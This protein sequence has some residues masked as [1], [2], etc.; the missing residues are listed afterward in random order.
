MSWYDC[1]AECM[2]VIV[3]EWW[4]CKRNPAQLPTLQLSVCTSSRQRKPS[5]Q[6]DHLTICE[7]KNWPMIKSW[8]RSSSCPRG[9]CSAPWRGHERLSL[10]C[11]TASGTSRGVWRAFWGSW[12]EENSS[13][14]S[15]NGKGRSSS[16]GKHQL[17]QHRWLLNSPSLQNMSDRCMFSIP[18]LALSGP[19]Q[20]LSHLP[21]EGFLVM[22]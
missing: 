19:W 14:R 5:L 9:R 11:H 16:D 4:D 3:G 20:L 2:I 7:N 10:E 21:G 8:L 17:C 13:S 18:I 12:S 1:F 15:R 6:P 22:T